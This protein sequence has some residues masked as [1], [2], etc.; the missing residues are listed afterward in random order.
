MAPPPWCRTVIFSAVVAAGWLALLTIVPWA[1][2][3]VY[4]IPNIGHTVYA[5]SRRGWF[6]EFTPIGLIEQDLKDLND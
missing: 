1:S 6:V 5:P 2:Y 4:P 3:G